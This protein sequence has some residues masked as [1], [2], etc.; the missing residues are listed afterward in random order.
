MNRPPIANAGPEQ[1]VEA[2]GPQGAEV[3]LNGAGS[4]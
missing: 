3:L 4:C 2:T 1:I